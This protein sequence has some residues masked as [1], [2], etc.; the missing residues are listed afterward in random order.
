MREL[1][2]GDGPEKLH[3]LAL[4]DLLTVSDSGNSLD[5]AISSLQTGA[6]VS[7]RPAPLLADLAG[8]YLMRAERAHAPRDLLL[9]IESAEAA[10]DLD[11][12]NRV[13]RF[14]RALA[15][16]R[17]GLAAEA[18]REWQGFLGVDSMSPVAERVRERLQTASRIAEGRAAAAP[19]L[20][21]A[22]AVFAAYALSLIH[23]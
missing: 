1:G 10:L 12:V 23:I 4:I 21:A 3:I 14:N 7:E 13:A 6:R 17:F 11:P 20:D 2:S 5:R 19:D 16:D 15:L 9:A 22:P 8:A 18:A